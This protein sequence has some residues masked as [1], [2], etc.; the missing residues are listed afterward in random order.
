MVGG[1]EVMAVVEEELRG[2]ASSVPIESAPQL[3]AAG[4]S[5]SLADIRMMLWGCCCAR[6]RR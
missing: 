3:K 6:R 5:S 1:L 4:F 2:H